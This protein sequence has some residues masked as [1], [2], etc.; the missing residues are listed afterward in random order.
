M[1]IEIINQSVTWKDSSKSGEYDFYYKGDWIG[2]VTEFERE[3]MNDALCVQM[4]RYAWESLGGNNELWG[5]NGIYS[6]EIATDQF[7]RDVI[8][9]TN[10]LTAR[11]L[12]K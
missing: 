3:K 8:N 9:G 5:H 11:Q 7:R 6:F 4:Y 10:H 2:R 1:G 12:N